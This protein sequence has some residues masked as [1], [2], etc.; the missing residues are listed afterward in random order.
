[1]T[2]PKL[3]VVAAWW[4]LELSTV[5]ATVGWADYFFSDR[6][7][8]D[9]YRHSDAN[10]CRHQCE[11]DGYRMIKLEVFPVSDARQIYLVQ[12]T[13]ECGSAGCES[14]VLLR[15]NGKM[16]RIEDRFGLDVDR[17][18]RI[19]RG[20]LDTTGRGGNLG[21]GNPFRKVI[22]QATKEIEVLG[23]VVTVGEAALIV[24]GV[25]TIVVMILLA[26]KSSRL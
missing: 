19:A 9:F 1:M 21:G 6:E 11:W 17:A 25:A 20:S 16:T 7:L 5:G 3:A 14:T 26:G 12:R 2:K 22:R 4:L 18:E 8:T 15:E 24:L 10:V 13:V 23:Y